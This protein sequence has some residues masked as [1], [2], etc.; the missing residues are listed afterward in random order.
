[1]TAGSDP[2]LTLLSS[3][4]DM[5]FAAHAGR[6]V[7]AHS[8]VHA[9]VALVRPFP[10]EDGGQL[11]Q[12]ITIGPGL[13]AGDRIDIRISV[14][15]GARVVVTT[16]AATRVLS[17][18]EGQYAEQRIELHVA[19]GATLEYYPAL[20]IPFPDSAFLQTIHVNTEPGAR[21]GLLETW[22]LGRTSRA[23]YLRFR[24]L[25]SR[26]LVHVDGTLV[27]AD[28]TELQPGRDR[29]DGAGV[30]AG[31]R[32]LTSAVWYGVTLPHDTAAPVDDADLVAVLA[33]SKPDVACFRAIG[34]DAPALDAAI[35]SITDH[36][37][38]AWTASPVRLDRFRC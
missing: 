28:A 4:A 12:L 1:M 29:L 21:V 22:A 38:A 2:E 37:A 27:Y 30:L 25:S 26:T 9:P 10:L 5:T 36:I 23:E 16:P 8:R 33:Q 18:N 35:R 3:G 7:L 14:S 11:V 32:Y 13:C 31:R 34:S 17:M 20:T 6:T 19:R 24:T 15:S